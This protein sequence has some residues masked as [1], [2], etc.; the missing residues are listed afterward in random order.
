MNF[1]TLFNGGKYAMEG[2]VMAHTLFNHNP[3]AKLFVLC[4][5]DSVYKEAV[6]LRNSYNIEPIHFTDVENRWP[7][8]PKSKLGRQLKEY[9]VSFKPFLPQYIFEKFNESAVIFVDADI[10]FWRDASEMFELFN[11]CSFFAKDHEIEPARSAGRFNVGLLGYKND[12]S[13]LKWLAWWQEKCIEW[14]Y[15]R[16]DNGRFAEQGY[17]NILHNQPQK[18]E[19]FLSTDHPGINL[20]PWN[21]M[22]HSISAN[23]DGKLLVDGQKLITYHYHEFE[24]RGDHYFPT[25]W[26]LPQNAR[27]LL[28]DPYFKLIKR[29]I[30][31]TLWR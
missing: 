16:A 31:N 18:F 19:G 10:A 14:C 22:K 2:W 1:C 9:I 28:Y 4:M 3:S 26:V 24:V 27:P 17:W 8:L 5:D 23:P 30:S 11:K 6:R 25:G 20:A 15:W 21:I 13:C 7:E 12:E 29:S